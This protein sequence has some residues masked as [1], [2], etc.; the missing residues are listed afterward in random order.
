MDSKEKQIED[1]FD[2]LHHLPKVATPSELYSKIETNI[3]EDVSMR[4]N[5][6]KYWQ[7]A[8]AVLIAFNTIAYL[9]FSPTNSDV[10]VASQ[11]DDYIENY[12]WSQDDYYEYL[13]LSE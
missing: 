5:T 8:A 2:S 12:N 10:E 11:Y 3:Y 6:H 1:I 7:Y 4:T 9:F 13:T